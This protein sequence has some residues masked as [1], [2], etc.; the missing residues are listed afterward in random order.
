MGEKPPR[1]TLVREY[2]SLQPFRVV[3]VAKGPS[4][5]IGISWQTRQFPPDNRR[6]IRQNVDTASA[7]AR[8]EALRQHREEPLPSSG[9]RQPR[10]G[11]ND[12]PTL[13]PQRPSM[14]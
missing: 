11:E 10:L 2:S 14:C 4:F 3:S 12:E 13:L 5:A 7:I 6:V 1:A 8:G 9:T